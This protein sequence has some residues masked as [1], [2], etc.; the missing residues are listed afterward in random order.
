MGRLLGGIIGDTVPST[1]NTPTIKGVYTT[2]G[3]YYI[4]QEGGWKVPQA[5]WEFKV[6]GAGGGGGHEGIGGGGAYVTGQY[7]LDESATIKIIV[8]AGGNGSGTPDPAVP[9]NP[10]LDMGMYGGGAPKGDTYAYNSGLGG[11][12]SGVIMESTQAYVSANNPGP[13]SPGLLNPRA[14]AGPM[15]EPGMNYDDILLLAGAGGGGTYESGITGGAYGGGGG[16]TQ[17]GQGAPIPQANGQPSGGTWDGSTVGPTAGT[18][19]PSGTDPGAIA[20]GFGHGGQ[21]SGG[22][23][24]GS[25]FRGGGGGGNSNKV[26]TGSGG[27]SF[28]RTPTMP[29]SPGIYDG[30]NP[31]TQSGTAGSPGSTTGNSGEAGNG[32][33]PV[34]GDTYGA[35]GA[36]QGKGQNGMVAYRRANSYGALPGASWT[37]VTMVGT[38]QPL[39]TAPS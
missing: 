30:W 14:E 2:N 39:S 26:G 38:D 16:V 31:G 21:T 4:K 37:V 32:P 3:I 27:S 22:G 8:G 12:L 11:G 15:R 9:G 7:Q 1:A 5:Y 10:G 29:S 34:N 35:G 19:G 28:W 25:G 17:G 18:P 20:G 33:D 36:V 13:T 6:W 23:G 24:G